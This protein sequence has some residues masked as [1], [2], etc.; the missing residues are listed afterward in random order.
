M[1]GV[2]GVE[3]TDKRRGREGELYTRVVVRVLR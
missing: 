3:E 2:E 1:E